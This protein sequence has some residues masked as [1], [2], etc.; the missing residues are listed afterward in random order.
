LTRDREKHFEE[1][2]IVDPLKDMKD[3]PRTGVWEWRGR[4]DGV[5]L[6]GA[7][8]TWSIPAPKPERPAAGFSFK[9]E[10]KSTWLKTHHAEFEAVKTRMISQDFLPS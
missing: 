3:L 2:W 5:E 10:I 7:V 1:Y 4:Q 8:A 6:S 9:L